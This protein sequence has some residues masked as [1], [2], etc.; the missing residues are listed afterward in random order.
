MEMW[1]KLGVD[2]SRHAERNL[3][4]SPDQVKRILQ[5]STAVQLQDA[6]PFIHARPAGDRVLTKL[7]E[8]AQPPQ[9][10]IFF[11]YLRSPL[12]FVAQRT[13]DQAWS[14]VP[15]EETGAATPNILSLSY[16]LTSGIKP[17]ESA[18]SWGFVNHFKNQQ[19][20]PLVQHLNDFLHSLGLKGHVYEYFGALGRSLIR[21]YS[22]LETGDFFVLA[23]P[24]HQVDRYVYDAKPYNVPTGKKASEVASNPLAHMD[25]LLDHGTHMA[26][27]PVSKETMDPS[28]GI[29]IINAADPQEVTTFCR[30]IDFDPLPEPY[31]TLIEAPS[32]QFESMQQSQRKKLDLELTSLFHQLTLHLRTGHCNPTPPTDDDIQPDDFPTQAI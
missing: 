9:S 23:I 19:Y 25:T 17:L 26:A 6:V 4:Q 28:S 10:G 7:Y 27:M 14:E 22:R 1:N 13:W 31:A 20:F 30:S 24:R 2:F 3:R 21:R 18:R 15:R 12:S 16:A 32:T 11:K 8:A 5:T 29:S